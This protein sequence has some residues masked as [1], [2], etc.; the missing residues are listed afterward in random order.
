MNFN[1]FPKV[2][3]HVHLDCC[4]SYEVVKVLN[5]AISYETYRESFIAPPKCIDLAD[6]IKRA[7][8]GFELMQTESQLRLV[9]RDLFRQLQADHVIYV[10]IRF[11]PLQ[12]TYQGLVP[13]EVVEI[14]NDE[15]LKCISDYNIEASIILCTLRHYSEE[16]SME[17][18][19][20]LQKYKGTLVSGF[21]IAA[22]E[23]GYPI[24]N[25]IKAFEFAH[26]HD[27]PCTAHAGEAKG[28]ESMW[29]TLR[30][31]HPH[32]I[33]HGV[34]C[35]EDESL[36]EY[37]LAEKIHLEVCPTSNIQTNVFDTMQQ[38]AADRI[39]N[40]GISMSINTDARTISDVTLSEEYTL[41]SKQ[42][43][44]NVNHFKTCNLEAIQHAFTSLETKDKLV[45]IIQESY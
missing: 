27:I 16:Q 12:H 6:Y 37:L 38:H 18:V 43:N 11:A 8:K 36:M 28:A 2:E 44:W 14:V 34:R 33:G 5:P 20:L 32:R 1:S 29:E 30:H 25:H 17:T 41:L 42:F 19:Q 3:L 21:D 15:T 9:T 24:H 31:F 10:E 23:A 7:I 22:D 40:K 35:V 13:E 4:L 45:K 39:F 26:A